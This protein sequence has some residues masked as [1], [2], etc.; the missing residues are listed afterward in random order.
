MHGNGEKRE[1]CR[2]NRRNLQNLPHFATSA[3]MEFAA[4]FVYP[5]NFRT[6]QTSPRGNYPLSGKCLL[7][8]N[9]P[10]FLIFLSEHYG[11]E[12][13]GGVASYQIGSGFHP[14]PISNRYR[15]TQIYSYPIH[16][17]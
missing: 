15:D 1:A 8:V 3:S 13:C 16:E 2:K 12:R 14:E 10:F 7:P 6:L 5:A 17:S 9:L 4:C 11:R